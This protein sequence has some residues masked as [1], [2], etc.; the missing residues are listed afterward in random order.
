MRSVS[1]VL[2]EVSAGWKNYTDVERNSIATAVAGTRQ[3]EAFLS[4]I[5]S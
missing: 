1:D 5:G 2:K 3:K 4:N